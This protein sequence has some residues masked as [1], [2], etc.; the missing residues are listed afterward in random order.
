MKCSRVRLSQTLITCL[1]F[2][3]NACSVPYLCL[4]QIDCNHLYYTSIFFTGSLSLSH[5]LCLFYAQPER[6]RASTRAKHHCQLMGTLCRNGII[7][8]SIYIFLPSF[9]GFLIEKINIYQHSQ[10]RYNHSNLG[11]ARRIQS[12]QSFY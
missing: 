8:T 3:V 4:S 5:P 12:L 2:A 11:C 7:K 1:H 9:F 6:G 10:A